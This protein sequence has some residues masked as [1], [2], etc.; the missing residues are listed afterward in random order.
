AARELTEETGL[1]LGHPPRL[2]GIAYLC[3]AVTP[4]ALPMRFNAR[5]LVA[6]AAAAHGDPAGSGELEDVRFYAVG[7]ATA[8][9]LVLVTREVL[10]R[11][12]AWIALPP[13][14]RQGRA[15]TDVFRQRKWRLE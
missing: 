3:R 2:D 4:P 14:L 7:E 13:S 12:M 1:S 10:D 6:D 9:D 8:L 5:F 11:F 15:Q